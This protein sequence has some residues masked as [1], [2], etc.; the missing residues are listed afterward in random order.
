[1]LQKPLAVIAMAAGLFAIQAYDQPA[2]ARRAATFSHAPRISM[3][4][5]RHSAPSRFISR[6]FVT[7]RFVGRPLV[8]RSRPFVHK[9]VIVQ[10]RFRRHH[11]FSRAFIG[12]PFG[13]YAYDSYAN[14]CSW[15]YWKARTTGSSYWW[16][17]YY[18]CRYGDGY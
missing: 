7:N 6:P 15:L 12:V 16:D 1:M 17:R 2:E 11:R 14:G 4:V 18:E 5:T 10:H 8:H 13:I 9:N 3:S